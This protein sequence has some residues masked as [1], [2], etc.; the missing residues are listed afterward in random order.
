MPVRRAAPFLLALLLTALLVPGAAQATSAA[1]VRAKLAKETAKLGRSAGAYVVDETSGTVLYS[2]RPDLALVPASNEKLFTTATA[3][4]TLGA[5]AT[6]E[7]RVLATLRPDGVS[8][9]DVYL[10]GAGDPSF[11]NTDLSALAATIVANGLKEVAGGVVGD[12]SFLDAKRGSADSAF[13]P[14]LDLGGQLGGL[15]V[16]HGGVDGM[17]PAHLAAA[18]LQALL[19]KQGVAFGRQARVGVAPPE[20][21]EQLATDLSPPLA[22]LVRATNQPSDNFFAEMLLKVVGAES[23]GAGTTLAGA[24]VVKREMADL[25]VLPTIADGSGLSRGNRTT[26][27][28]VVTLL[29]AMAAGESATA[30]LGSLTVAGRNGTL[31]RRMRG[32]PAAGRCSGKTGTLRGV[33]ALSGYCTTTGG[34]RVVFSFIENGV[35]GGAKAVEDRMVAALARF[36]G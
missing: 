29:R 8:V 26:T 35:G 28:Q 3:L 16:G 22:E 6:R 15:V 17:G 2:R 31:R 21:T 24:T 23:G 7:T 9:Q 10:V 19:K 13:K 4:I 32:T 20:A 34:R 33:S 30:W 14:D 1:T 5:D 12:G 25:G 27:R 36:S 18:R 11:S